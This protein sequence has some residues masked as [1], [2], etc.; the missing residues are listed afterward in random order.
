MRRMPW[1]ERDKVS[2]RIQFVNRLRA[3]ERMSDLCREFGISR[4]TGYKFKER[5]GELGV[6]GLYDRCRRPLSVPHRTARGVV[7]HIV[8]LRKKHPSWGPKTLKQ[9]LHDLM[10]EVGWPAAS[11]IGVILKDEGLVDGRKRRRRA[12]PTP[13]S[14]RR[15]SKAPNE[16]WCIDFK[17]QFRLGNRRYCY[18]LTVTDHFSRYLVACEALSNTKVEPAAHTLENVFR[19]YGLPEAIR[20]DNGTPFASTGRAGLS[21]FSV[22]LMRLGIRLER[23]DPGHPE[24]NGRHERMHR[25]LKQGATRP[26]SRNMLQQQERFDTFQRVFNDERPHHALDLKTPSSVYKPAV[27]TLPDRLPDVTYPL[28]EHVRYVNQYGNINIPTRTNVYL[29]KALA[30]QP[31]GIRAIEP[32]TLLLSFMDIDIGYFDQQTKKIIDIGTTTEA[33][34]V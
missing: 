12:S 32:G 17:G 24:Q 1:E 25:T 28:C 20:S 9:R 5:Y 18:P 15:E 30:G 23:I 6:E 27:R 3:G 29:S 16:L 33:A 4:K 31:I 11:T 13:P 26:P 10:P 7:E 19:S 8:R 2:E 14:E 22:W 21:T 34:N